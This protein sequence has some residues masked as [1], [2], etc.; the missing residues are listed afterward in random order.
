[1]ILPS[2]SSKISTGRGRED[3]L[4][5]EEAKAGQNGE[6]FLDLLLLLLAQSS[7]SFLFLF[8]QMFQVELLPSGHPLP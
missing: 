2:R 6:L 5:G 1:M 3:E 7:E 8:R 4:T